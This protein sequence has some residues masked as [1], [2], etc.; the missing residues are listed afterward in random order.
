MIHGRVV[1][2][3]HH[4]AHALVD[5]VAVDTYKQHNHGGD[6]GPDNFEGQISF[7]CQSVA[8]I[9]AATTE[10]EQA[11]NQQDHDADKQHGAN[12]E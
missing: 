4:A 6:G 12:A 10:F 8:Q 3:G 1:I 2:E 7:D 9:T 5:V 11:V